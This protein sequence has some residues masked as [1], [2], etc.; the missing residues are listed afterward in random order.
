MAVM[1]AAISSSLAHPNVVATYTYSIKPVRDTTTSAAAI[2]SGIIVLSAGGSM[3]AAAA[4]IHTSGGDSGSSLAMVHSYEV[5][6]I[7][8]GQG[9]GSKRPF[10]LKPAHTPLPTLQLPPFPLIGASGAKYCDLGSLREALDQGAFLPPH[11][12]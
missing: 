4:S 11:F 5:G 8:V 9:G 7:C 3:S 10:L 1:E 2:D 12:N 6:N